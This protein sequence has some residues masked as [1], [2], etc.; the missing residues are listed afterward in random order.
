MKGKKILCFLLLSVLLIS[1]CC[2]SFVSSASVY[3]VDGQAKTTPGQTRTYVPLEEFNYAWIDDIVVRDSSSSVTPLTLVPVTDNPYSH[4]LEEYI[5]ECNDYTSLFNASDC[6]LESTF[7]T[8][9]RTMYY[10][11]IASG[12]ITENNSEMRNYN[13]EHGISYPFV[14]SDL[15]QLYTAIVYVSLKTDL[16]SA[17]LDKQIEIPR[18]TTVEGA[19]VMILSS[20]CNMEVPATVN[21][22]TAFS[23][24]FAEDYVLEDEKYPVS[25]DPT[26]AEVYYWIQ[27]AAAENAGYSVPSDV[28]YSA[29]TME[30][31]EYVTYAYYASILTSRYE[32]MVDPLLLRAALLSSDRDTKVPELVLKAMLD[33][34]SISYTKNESVADLFNKA[35]TEGFFDL[36]AEFYTDIYNYEVYV[37]PESEQVWFTCYLIADQLVDGDINFAETFVNGEKV[38]NTSTTGVTLS[39]GIETKVII[40]VAYNDGARNDSATYSFVVKKDFNA[41]DINGNLSIDVADPVGS[42]L[43]SLTGAADKYLSDIEI[44]TI[45][46]YQTP[47]ANTHT[48][49]AINDATTVGSRFETYPTDA[50]GNI[51]NNSNALD[52]TLSQGET[53]VQVLDKTLA[54]TVKENPEYVATP[55]G[56][57]AVG[58]SAGYIFFR[59]RKNELESEVND[60]IE[61]DNIDID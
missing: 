37:T 3:Y 25:D 41:A 44:P 54:E 17:I 33:D 22:L 10:S 1:V 24:L 27:L 38:K 48:T 53:T 31:E 30:Q 23:Y 55:I 29:V 7:V 4:T 39:D 36:E 51:I 40:E 9:L 46:E 2:G 47:S 52:T 6:V 21:T 13:E 61:V 15:T 28:P 12:V 16:Y 45:P 59:R 57:L 50:N 20:I 8:S 32:V 43:D 11:L 35:R 42:V 5:K 26:E 14:E 60:D 34:V 56:L 49:Y 19:I 18:G 58:A